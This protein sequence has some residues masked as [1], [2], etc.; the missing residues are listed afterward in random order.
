[1]NKAIKQ[2][3]KMG[4]P[5]VYTEVMSNKDRQQRWRDKVKADALSLLNQIKESEVS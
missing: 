1:M 3:K 5:R 4:R 2:P